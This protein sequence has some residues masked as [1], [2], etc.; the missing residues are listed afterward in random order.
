MKLKK[1]MMWLA[2]NEEYIARH[3]AIKIKIDL[4]DHD[5]LKAIYIILNKQSNFSF[6]LTRNYLCSV[7]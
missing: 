1:N 7:L 3:E 2:T 6:Y 5:I 4:K